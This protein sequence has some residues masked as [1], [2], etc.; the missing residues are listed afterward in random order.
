[1]GVHAS[2]A[3]I[4][5]RASR[6]L[7]GAPPESQRAD[8]ARPA[9]FYLLRD[10]F[11]LASPEV[12]KAHATSI[13]R[14]RTLFGDAVRE[15]S[16]ADI[17]GSSAVANFDVWFD[18]YCVI[19]WSEI[20]NSLGPW[21]AEAKPVFGPVTSKSL[22]LVANLDRRRVPPAIVERERVYRYLRNFLGPRDLLCIPTTPAPA[23][24]KGSLG[25]NPRTGD[26][27]KRALSLTSIAGIGR[28]PQVS[29]PLSEI[30]IDGKLL[31]LGLSLLGSFGEDLFVL[32][33]AEQITAAVQ[34]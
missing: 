1:M 6:I 9:A 18:T 13:D 8:N 28:L 2:S 15:I 22:E 3:E 5:K 29:M 27:Y 32:G 11:E 30:V 25:S 12:S 33:V 4:L 19:Q 14:L 20:E 17:F 24:I 10:A 7:L 34:V 26:Y 21:I 23:P 16:L 31:P